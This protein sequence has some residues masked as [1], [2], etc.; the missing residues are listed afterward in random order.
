MVVRDGGV[1]HPFVF[2]KHRVMGLVPVYRLMYC[3]SIEEFARYAGSLGRFLLLRGVPLVQFDANG[4]VPGLFG[5]Y[6][7]KRGRK[8]AKG[9]H[10]PHLWRLVAFTEAAMFDS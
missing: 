7:T 6:S 2:Q 9:A 8:Y 1:D 10:P 4:P 5:W 3:R